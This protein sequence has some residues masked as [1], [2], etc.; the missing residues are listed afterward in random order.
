MDNLLRHQIKN[1]IDSRKENNFQEFINLLF[2]KRYGTSFSPIKA[3][4]DK[5]CDG[6][7]NNQIIIAVYAPHKSELRAFKKKT[8]DD[9]NSYKNNWQSHYPKWQYVFNGEYTASMKEYLISL[10]SDVITLDIN[11]ILEVIEELTHD[12]KREILTCLGINEQY[13][14]YDIM[15]L[16]VEDIFKTIEDSSDN[17]I[18]H[19]TP[20][21][22]EDKI[23]INYDISDVDDA[24]KQYEI[25]VEYFSQL[26]SILINY[27][28]YD[29]SSLKSKL[30]NSYS[31]LIGNFKTRLSNLID[32]FTANNKNDDLYVF[33]VRV[34]LIYFFEICVIGKKPESEQ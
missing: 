27:S 17:N 25:V 3:K 5:G 24:M 15:T 29:I 10:R 14:I 26:Q 22:I 32:E 6:I 31:K 28:D 18:I 19:T 33:F 13:I 16:V 21:Y 7:L 23:R 20:P 34:V 12:K 8:K 4:H 9:Y 11:G 2:I 1:A 30:L